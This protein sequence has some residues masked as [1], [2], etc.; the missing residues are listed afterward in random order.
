M[1]K[2]IHNIDILLQK[3]C[4]NKY[5]HSWVGRD[6]KWKQRFGKDKLNATSFRSWNFT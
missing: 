1:I 4:A 5:T 2:K 3:A 6:K